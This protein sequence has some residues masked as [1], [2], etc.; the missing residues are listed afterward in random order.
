MLELRRD[1]ADQI[2]ADVEAGRLDPWDLFSAA[3]GN[4]PGRMAA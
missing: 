3:P 4:V 1:R 2:R